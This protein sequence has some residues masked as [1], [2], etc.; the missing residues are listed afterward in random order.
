MIT[1]RA[2]VVSLNKER[3]LSPLS[4]RSQPFYRAVEENISCKCFNSSPSRIALNI[5]AIYGFL[6]R[7]PQVH[8]GFSPSVDTAG[9]TTKISQPQLRFEQIQCSPLRIQA[10]VTPFFLPRARR[11]PVKV[12][13]F[14]GL[15]ADSAR[16]VRTVL[17]YKL[18]ASN[19]KQA[20]RACARTGASGILMSLEIFSDIIRPHHLCSRVKT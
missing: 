8:F 13:E 10:T 1:I 6:I 4:L 5:G 7:N 18:F 12:V 3:A 16:R 11:C 9:C 15:N 17:K 19:R 2:G 20:D 14:S